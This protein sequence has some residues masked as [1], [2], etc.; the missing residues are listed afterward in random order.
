MN[1]EK[2]YWKDIEDNMSAFNFNNNNKIEQKKSIQESTEIPTKK[3][4]DKVI[5][6]TKDMI[7]D[8]A[9]IINYSTVWWDTILKDIN[10]STLTKEQVMG[11]VTLFTSTLNALP[12]INAAD[13]CVEINDVLNQNLRKML[14]VE[15]INK[16]V[17]K[18]YSLAIEDMLKTIY[19]E[20]NPL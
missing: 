20:K 7:F 14:Q 9:D 15:N 10:I 6:T 12:I 19:N 3:Y 2:K 17:I 16:D 5:E 11:F 8:S 4:I 13:L 1:I 18:G